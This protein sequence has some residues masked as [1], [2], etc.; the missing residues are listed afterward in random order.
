[1]PIKTVREIDDALRR[2]FLNRLSE[3]L[4]L[5]A[6]GTGENA[7]DAEAF[8]F[9]MT[10]GRVSQREAAALS[11]RFERP[12][13]AGARRSRSALA[14]PSKRATS[15]SGRCAQRSRC[16]LPSSPKAMKRSLQHSHPTAGASQSGARRSNVFAKP[17]AA[18][19]P[20]RPPPIGQRTLFRP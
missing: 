8:S 1:M 18:S 20:R 3:R 11:L 10:L 6:F 2:R 4:R 16:P 13:A 17:R 12:P 9:R 19:P 7:D 5:R 14:G 15:P